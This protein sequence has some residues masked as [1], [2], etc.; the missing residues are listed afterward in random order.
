MSECDGKKL[1]V[2]GRR[3][4]KEDTARCIEE[5]YESDT[6][7]FHQCNRKRG[8]GPNGEYCEQHAAMHERMRLRI[9][10]LKEK[11]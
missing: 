2:Y 9:E 3:N 6:Y 7:T 10:E 1:R 11:K 5:V 4:T 8:H